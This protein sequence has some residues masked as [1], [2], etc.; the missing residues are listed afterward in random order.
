MT[1]VLLSFAVLALTA[2]LAAPAAA[3]DD[4]KKKKK[5]A[6][7]GPEAAALFAKLDANK[8]EKV[9]KDEFATFKGLKEPKKEGKEAKGVVAK[10]DDWFKKLD[11]NT[12]G[13]L[14]VAEFGKLKEVVAANPPEKK[15]KVK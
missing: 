12:D 10:R 6:K 13:S 15:K 7:K 8:D 1:R 5:E 14:T 11:A 9:S 2:V 3:Q 4:A